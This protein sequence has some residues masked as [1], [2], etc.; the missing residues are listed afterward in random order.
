MRRLTYVHL[1]LLRTQY[2]LAVIFFAANSIFSCFV[3]RC[4]LFFAPWLAGIL[5]IFPKNNGTCPARLHDFS[6]CP[7]LWFCDCYRVY[8]ELDVCSSLLRSSLAILSIFPKKMEQVQLAC[9][10]SAQVQMYGFV[11]FLV[12]SVSSVRVC[13]AS[14]LDN[15]L[16]RFT[17]KQWNISS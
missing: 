15:I 11:I 1:D 8:W 2:S 4:V 16:A 5:A 3:V 12:F 10:T 13:I 17:K 7:H 14:W 9:T 6:A